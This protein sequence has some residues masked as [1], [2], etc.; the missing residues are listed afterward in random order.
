MKGQVVVKPCH[1]PSKLTEKIDGE[2]FQIFNQKVA[3]L[4]YL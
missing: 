2:L 1:F 3:L 4:L